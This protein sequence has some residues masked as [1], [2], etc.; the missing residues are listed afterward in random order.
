MATLGAG[1]DLTSFPVGDNEI[2]QYKF[3]TIRDGK[4]FTSKLNEYSDGVS[5][6]EFYKDQTVLLRTIGFAKII[7]GDVIAD[8]DFISSDAEGCAV[9]TK[10]NQLILAKALEKGTKG[11]I[12]EVILHKFYNK[13]TA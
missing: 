5:L 11:Q 10:E 8:G 4:V 2:K 3:C 7:C 1:I 9:K 12:I 13:G 6:N